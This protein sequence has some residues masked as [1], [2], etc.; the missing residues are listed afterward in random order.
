MQ[1]HRAPAFWRPLRNCFLEFREVCWSTAWATWR[2]AMTIF[3]V[4]GCFTSGEGQAP[5]YQPAYPKQYAR[6]DECEVFRQNDTYLKNY[7]KGVRNGQYQRDVSVEVLCMKKTVTDGSCPAYA[8]LGSMPG[9]DAHRRLLRKA[10]TWC[11]SSMRSENS[12]MARNL[13]P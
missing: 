8:W 10:K 3:M 13:G 6:V 2:T 7:L 11:P 5:Q 4:F 9:T 12:G 1:M